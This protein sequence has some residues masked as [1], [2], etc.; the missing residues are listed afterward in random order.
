MIL[1]HD[2]NYDDILV[3]LALLQRSDLDLK[4]VM[5]TPADCELD[6]AVEVTGKVLPVGHGKWK[7]RIKTEPDT[8]SNFGQDQS[9]LI[10]RYC[11]EAG[12]GW[13]LKT[14]SGSAIYPA[15]ISS[16]YQ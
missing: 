16:N 11:A 14:I 4:A 12:M 15:Y 9:W 6:A 1:D 13:K 8:W 3:L 10:V 5:V 7:S 2:G